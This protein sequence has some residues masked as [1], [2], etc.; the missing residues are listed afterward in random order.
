MLWLA[1]STKLRFLC[2]CSEMKQPWF[3]LVFLPSDQVPEGQ[4]GSGPVA[5]LSVT[6]NAADAVCQSHG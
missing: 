6:S 1:S 3:Y 4:T 5:L 2:E